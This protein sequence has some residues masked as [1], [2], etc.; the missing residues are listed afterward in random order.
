MLGM[1]GIVGVYSKDN[2]GM[3]SLYCLYGVQH[4]GQE[5]AGV[6]AAGDRSIRK[7]SGVGLVSKVFDEHYRS[8]TH[9][10]DYA[11]IGCA[12]GESI[13]NGLSPQILETERYSI[14]LALDGFISKKVGETNENAFSQILLD[15]LEQTTIIPALREAMWSLPM[16]YY[17]IVAVVHDKKEMR[18]M[19]VALRD[20]R[21]VRPLHIARSMGK[22]FI[23]SESAPLDVLEGMGEM[24]DDRRDVVPG[25]LLY[26]TS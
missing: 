22:L 17:S 4:R 2:A 1:E 7:W 13:M 24:F 20:P 3:K 11:V 16:A 9:P 8:F 14:A 19:L 15:K 18:S 6:A 12:S 21:G 10:D 25:S 5:S 23:A 26:I